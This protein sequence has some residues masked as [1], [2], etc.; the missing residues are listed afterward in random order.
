MLASTGFHHVGHA[1]KSV[2]PRSNAGQQAMARMRS[3]VGGRGQVGF[4][5]GAHISRFLRSAVG[6]ADP[7]PAP[8]RPPHDLVGP[9]TAISQRVGSSVGGGPPGTGSGASAAAPLALGGF[10]GRQGFGW[11]ASTARA[12]REASP[13]RRTNGNG[14]TADGIRAKAGRERGFKPHS[15]C[16]TAGPTWTQAHWMLW[17]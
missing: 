12:E 16:V 3:D 5:P 1:A 14:L 11:N 17:W 10:D 9:H 4:L 6:R 8:S 15:T 7:P 2:G 13:A